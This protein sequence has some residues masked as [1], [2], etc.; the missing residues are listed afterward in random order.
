[1]K[2]VHICC[3]CGKRSAAIWCLDVVGRRNG[4]HHRPAAS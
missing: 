1:V 4:Y 2:A 3:L